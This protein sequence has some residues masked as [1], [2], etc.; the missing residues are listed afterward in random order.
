MKTKTPTIKLAKPTQKDK[1]LILDSLSGHEHMKS[2][3]AVSNL[4]SKIMDKSARKK[5]TS[6]LQ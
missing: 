6:K 2:Q 4:T 5:F 3:T 1:E